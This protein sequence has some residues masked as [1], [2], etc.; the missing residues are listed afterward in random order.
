MDVHIFDNLDFQGSNNSCEG[1]AFEK[2][3]ETTDHFYDFQFF[4]N[5]IEPV[6]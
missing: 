6:S 4:F 2:S 1:V 5:I 3:I